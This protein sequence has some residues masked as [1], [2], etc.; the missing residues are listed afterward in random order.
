[1][2]SAYAAT[3]LGILDASPSLHV[4]AV[5]ASQNPLAYVA[6]GGVA[7]GAYTYSQGG[8]ASDVMYSTVAGAAM[9]YASGPFP[10]AGNSG[11][12]WD[13]NSNVPNQLTA[14]QS[15][16]EEQLNNLG[17]SKNTTVFQPTPEQAQSSA[18]QVIVGEPQYT[19][20]GQ[21]VGTIADSTDNGLLEIKGG[22]STLNSSYQL[23]LQVYNS[24]VN[25]IPMQIQ[26]TRPV[27][28]TFNNYLQRW[29][30]QVTSPSN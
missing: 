27:N 1:M 28:P 16:E 11:A 26:T 20:G 6:A 18:F 9:T 5:N 15:F 23:R 30:V 12:A 10:I 29:G 2:G 4:A 8:S 7:T 17:V 14:G 25:N 13:P 19:P 3:G 24:V 21:L 22:S